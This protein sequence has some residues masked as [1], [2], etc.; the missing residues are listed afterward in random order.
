[1]GK[2]KTPATA[3]AKKV[4]RT[5]RPVTFWA[6]KGIWDA[7]DAFMASLPYKT[8]Y[9]DH[10]NLALKEYLQAKGYWPPKPEE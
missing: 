3:E 1:M 5:G 7:L 10:I 2:K 8:G 4:A 9:T 6:D